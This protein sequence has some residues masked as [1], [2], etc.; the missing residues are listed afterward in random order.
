MMAVTAVHIRPAEPRDVAALLQL[1]GAL[2]REE[3]AIEAFLP[4]AELWSRRMFG[5]D[6]NFAALIAEHQTT[7]IGLLTYNLKHYT[8]WPAP[9]LFLQDIFVE[10]FFRRRGI[11]LQLMRG[12]AK[13]AVAG[14]VEH[15]ELVVRADNPARGFYEHIGLFAVEEAVTYI[16]DR[17]TIQSL[18]GN[19]SLK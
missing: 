19:A 8:G 4:D 17:V 11:A 14:G 16:G 7:A 5:R 9:A 18:A 3:G 2:Q 13:H 12:L 10:P 1:K 15:I 6:P